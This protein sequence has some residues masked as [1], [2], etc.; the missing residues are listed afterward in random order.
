MSAAEHIARLDRSIAQEGNTVILRRLLTNA[1]GVEQVETEITIPAHVRAASPQD[2]ISGDDVVDVAVVISSTSIG[3]FG[4]PLRDDR[5]EI[6]GAPYNIQQ[7][8]PI[9]YG[10]ALVRVNMVCRG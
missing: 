9:Y 6:R 5:I 10:A 4:I 7:I 1:D 8:A 2:L 3:D